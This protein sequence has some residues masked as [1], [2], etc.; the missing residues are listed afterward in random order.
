MH[1]NDMLF[2]RCLCA[3]VELETAFINRH[4]TLFTRRYQAPH[5]KTTCACER[6]TFSDIAEVVVLWSICMLTM[7]DTKMSLFQP[8]CCMEIFISRCFSAT[9]I[10]PDHSL[11][12]V[13]LLSK[14]YQLFCTVLLQHCLFPHTWKSSKND[15][16]IRELSRA[17]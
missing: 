8:N 5:P 3:C 15:F 12:A 1:T 7:V 4:S 9:F 13:T 17:Q 2:G 6:V 11:H 16:E 14:L 10:R